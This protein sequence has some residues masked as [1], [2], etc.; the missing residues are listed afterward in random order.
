MSTQFYS[1]AGPARGRTDPTEVHAYDIGDEASD[2]SR[3]S[4]ERDHFVLMWAGNE[5]SKN[6]TWI[7]ADD[8]S[9]LNLYDCR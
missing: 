3:G 7:S 9:T 5:Y 8:K 6:N 1:F 4:H 2:M